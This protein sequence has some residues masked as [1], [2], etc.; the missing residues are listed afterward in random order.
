MDECTHYDKQS[1]QH[2]KYSHRADPV[3]AER[4]IVPPVQNIAGILGWSERKIVHKILTFS[5]DL[6]RQ[7]DVAA[8]SSV[9]YVGI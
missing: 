5:K 8:M 2:G 6:P 4:T 1:T 9:S 7:K 3:F